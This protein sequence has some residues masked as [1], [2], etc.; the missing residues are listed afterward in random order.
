VFQLSAQ[1]PGPTSP[2][3][4]ITLLL[5]SDAPQPAHGHSSQPLRQFMI[6]SK[7]CLH[8]ECPP[9]QGIIRGSYES[10][11]FIREVPAD[12]AGVKRSWS[13]ADLNTS[14]EVTPRESTSSDKGLG[15]GAPTTIEWLMVT[16]SDP[17]GSVPRFMIEK[18]TP[19][20]I[21]NDA[22][23]FINWL[24]SKPADEPAAV[25]VVQPDG[26]KQVVSVDAPVEKTVKKEISF[27]PASD[28]QRT[29][30]Q[31]GAGDD[32]YW[33]NGL[34]GMIT[35]AFEAASSVVTGG[36]RRQFTG[37]KPDYPDST[38]S[39]QQL[40][41]SEDESTL[42]DTSSIRS[43]TSA[44]ERSLTA[45]KDQ[46]SLQGS[47][48]DDK[49]QGNVPQAKE[50]KKLQERR[51]KLDEKAAKMAERI[52]NRR[53][54][55]K[56]RDAAALVKAREKHEREIAKHEAKYKR[57]LRKIEEKRE[58]EE[59]KAE[60]RRRKALEREEKSNLALEL[61]KARAE[62]D[63]AL[64]QM[65]MLKAQVGELQAQ[66]TMLVARL[67]KQNTS[68]KADSASTSS[69]EVSRGGIDRTASS[70]KV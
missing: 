44:L 24:N 4:F 30:V 50:L 41:E 68:D 16:R 59:R 18:G 55:D 62:R 52:E 65:E 60:E 12:H 27:V 37:A 36:L 22:G 26:T 48:S 42:S 7:P 46:E 29:I 11:E 56:E 63:I 49:S 34:F 10:V 31:Q 15:S 70:P 25:E 64:K 43:F 58:A 5:T 14:K 17:G 2:R 51:R 53:A 66:N 6:V 19:P 8:A 9:R 21:V 69:K 54:G 40:D 33:S 47:Q 28:S 23:K 32:A 3:D 1:F 38:A 35:G 57:E 45:E 13:S 67:G 61:E 20:G 39:S